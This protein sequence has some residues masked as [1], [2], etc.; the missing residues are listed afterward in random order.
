VELRQALAEAEDLAV[1]YVLP[2]GQVNAKTRRFIAENRLGED[3][4]F[5]TDPGS[6]VIGALGLAKADPEPIEVGVPHPATYLIDREGRIRLA[7]VRED[8]H[9]WLASDVVLDALTDL[10]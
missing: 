5:L 2:E 9:I 1:V 6:R 10:D 3:V 4:Y 8:F 7:D